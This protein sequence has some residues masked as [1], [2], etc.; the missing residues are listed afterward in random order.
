[1]RHKNYPVKGVVFYGILCG[2]NGNNGAIRKDL[3]SIL[4]K[5]DN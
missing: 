1:M 3:T 2:I 5:I 4:Y